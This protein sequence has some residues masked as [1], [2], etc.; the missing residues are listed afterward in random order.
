LKHFN[1]QK[2]LTLHVFIMGEA[3]VEKKTPNDIDA[4]QKGTDDVSVAFPDVCKT[5]S[6]AGP[7]PIPY[8]NVA[9]A[10]DVSTGSKTVKMDGKATT[11]KDASSYAKS[12]GD[13]PGHD[14]PMVMFG[15]AQLSPTGTLKRM[16]TS[17]TLGIPRWVWGVIAISGLVIVWVLTSNALQP[18]VPYELS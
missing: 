13:E 4:V 1:V 18:I 16:L 8:P 7:I 6:P 11:V 14:S 5:P 3:V 15:T 17:R 2:N 12:T 10:T 9:S